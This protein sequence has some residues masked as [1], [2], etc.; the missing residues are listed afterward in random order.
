MISPAQLRAARALLG[1]SAADLAERSGLSYPT[2]QRAENGT[3]DARSS[4]LNK[5]LDTFQ[6]AGIRFVDHGVSLPPG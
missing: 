6:A 5:M 4:T 3:T 2:V 1:W